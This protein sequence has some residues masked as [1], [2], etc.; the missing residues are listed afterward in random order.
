[1]KEHRFLIPPSN[2][3]I[4]GTSCELGD[5]GC[6]HINIADLSEEL[7]LIIR[8]R[9]A[10]ICH[11]VA[12]ASRNTT[13][14]SYKQTVRSF[15]RRYDPK[16]SDTKKGMIGEL[17]THVLFLHYFDA[18][19]PAS[20]NFNLE[21]ESIKKGFDLVLINVN[22]EEVWFAEVK[23]GECTGET[24]SQKLGG[25]LSVAKN[26]LKKNLGSKRETLWHNAVNGAAIAMKAGNLKEKIEILL[27]DYAEKAPGYLN[28][29]EDFNAIL[30]AVCFT[31][32]LQRATLEEFSQKHRYHLNQVEFRELISLSIQKSTYLAVEE[33]L[34][35]ET[36]NG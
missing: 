1:M 25:L 20:P 15:L 24:S 10:E 36:L 5:D 27:E 35:Q 34:R 12:K 3:E 30:V 26:D 13:L 9:L 29:S 2:K 28:K 17:L 14:Y 21:E 31:G 4:C 11:G 23:S 22:T 8:A 6:V 18:Y 7:K 19:K 33:F 16:A 32:D